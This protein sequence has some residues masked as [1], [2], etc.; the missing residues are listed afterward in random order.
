MKALSQNNEK[1]DIMATKW[2]DSL[3]GSNPEEAKKR[4][5]ILLRDAFFDADF[6]K[7]IME[8]SPFPAVNV[9]HYQA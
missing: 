8:I 4:F 1:R 9:G 2:A 5:E 7:M 6:K 3:P